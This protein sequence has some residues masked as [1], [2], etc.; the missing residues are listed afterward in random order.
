METTAPTKFLFRDHQ[1]TDDDRV[2]GAGSDDVSSVH[3]DDD[4][5][6]QD[7]E[8]QSMT[9]MGIKHLCSELVELKEESDEDFYKAILSDYTTFI[10][11][12]EEV[13]VMEHEMDQLKSHVSDQK[14]LVDD[15]MDGL[16]ENLWMGEVNKARDD[17]DDELIYMSELD[18]HVAE[19]SETLDILLVENRLDEALTILEKENEDL[20]RME[21]ENEHPPDMLQ[22]I[23]SLISEVEA[24]VT[25]QLTRFAENP[26]ISAPELQTTLARLKRLGNGSIVNQLLFK[27]YHHR[28]ATGTRRLEH[29]SLSFHDGIY[30]RDLS[31][32]VFS[33]VSQAAK[34]FRMLNGEE[35]SADTRELTQWAEEEMKEF[36]GTFSTYVKSISDI[37]GGLLTAVH[38]ME[39]ALSYCSLLEGQGID[40]SDQ[41]VDG[42]R[43]CM[44]EVLKIHVEHYKKVIRIF[45]ASDDWILGK[46]LV[47]GILASRD[48]AASEGEYPECCYLSNS[49]RK[50]VTLLQAIVED[51]SPMLVL[52]MQTSIFEGL[53]DIYMEYVALLKEAV[54]YDLSHN[55]DPEVDSPDMLT[56][57]VSIVANVSAMEDLF[58]RMIESNV[59]GDGF[60][61]CFS[62]VLEATDLLRSRFCQEFTSRVMSL[63]SDCC[64]HAEIREDEQS[65]G[66]FD[67]LT[68]SPF[69]QVLFLELRKLERLS[70]EEAF[71]SSRLPEL[72][73][74]LIEAA[75]A[76]L[77]NTRTNLD[78]DAY[79]H[80]LVL[81]Y[82]EN[83]EQF[84]VDSRFLVE[85]AEQGGYFSED[86]SALE[87]LS[88]SI[89]HSANPTLQRNIDAAAKE[90]VRRLL[91]FE[92]EEENKNLLHTLG[93]SDT[94]HITTEAEDGKPPDVS[95]PRDV[96]NTPVVE[97]DSVTTTQ[98]VVEGLHV[99]EDLEDQK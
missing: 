75:F 61:L 80:D 67:G 71:D 77:E 20:L 86:P 49:G 34:S 70:E 29:L 66:G 63:G 98:S 32:L 94:D 7:D 19:V 36:A 69:F 44:E 43:P 31:K 50:L 60:D 27:Y 11:I 9:A 97:E 51:V 73:R 65:L 56:R 12:F 87:S 40:L 23:K 96:T 6:G 45:T 42:I 39:F 2:S 92:E 79:V 1:D 41:L 5:D 48:S 24:T 28:I 52:Q 46:Y 14:K 21:E 57:Q 93:A 15:L 30:I 53:R 90:S 55:E 10:R 91:E 18:A 88:N 84:A 17:S 81:R 82:R 64:C 95:S 89:R 76:W 99:I 74:E 85:I 62:N 13:G 78:S 22:P 72:L 83:P 35:K 16:H 59:P 54:T 26:R 25:L 38:C 47:S 4:F 8:F 3:T 33:L 68:P 58:C 37:N